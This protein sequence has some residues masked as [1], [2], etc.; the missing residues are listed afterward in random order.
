MTEQQIATVVQ[1]RL[2]GN[3]SST[4]TE[5]TGISVNT[6]KSYCSRHGI[7]APQ[8]VRTCLLCHTTITTAERFCSDA[9]RMVWYESHQN[10]DPKL[11]RICKTCRTVFELRQRNQA[12]C[13]KQCFYTD[14][15]HQKLKADECAGNQGLLA[16]VPREAAV[17]IVSMTIDYLVKCGWELVN[18]E[19]SP[20]PSCVVD[21]LNFEFQTEFHSRTK[22]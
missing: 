11:L 18:N 22:C 14:R 5:A 20:D 13:S 16:S 10:E 19:C 17:A 15:Y 6:I 7:P 8:R 3:S 2:E 9:C 1:L 4:I 12:Y 21:A